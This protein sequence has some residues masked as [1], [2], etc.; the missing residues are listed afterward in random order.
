MEGVGSWLSDEASLPNNDHIVSERLKTSAT[1]RPVPLERTK[2]PE[3]HI[4]SGDFEVQVDL[5][6]SITHEHVKEPLGEK[7]R[8]T[9]P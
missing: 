5:R 8:Q 9:A 3:E 4:L 1:D 7:T 2:Q 6:G